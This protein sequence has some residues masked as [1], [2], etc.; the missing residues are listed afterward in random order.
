METRTPDAVEKYLA[1][2]EGTVLV[3]VNSVCGCAAANARPGVSVAM[4]H[5]KKP[6]QAITVFAGNDAQATAKARS[7]FVG[8]QPSSPQIAL[9]KDGDVVFMLER[10]Q[11]TGRS[12]EE[13]G[14]EIIE[15]FEKFC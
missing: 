4:Q 2:G 5:H 1:P 8:Y 6:D 11:I 15:N 9:I 3:V 7:Y 12:A 10:H 13:I 14:A